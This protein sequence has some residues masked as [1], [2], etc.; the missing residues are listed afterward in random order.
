M[1]SDNIWWTRKSRIQTAER[2]L[3]NDFHTQL[4]LVWYSLFSAAVAIYYLKF[5]PQSDLVQ[6]F[7]AIYSVMILSMSLFMSG[8]NFKERAMLMKQ[9]YEQLGVL[10]KKA[11]SFQDADDLGTLSKIGEDYQYIINASENHKEIDYIVTLVKLKLSN[12]DITRKPSWFHY[13]KTGYYFVFRFVY[14]TL[15][16]AAPVFALILMRRI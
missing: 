4:I 5:D 14:L 11:K 7:M 12:D 3:A 2:L 16:Y 15:F 10:Y 6:V 1:L 13:V 9:C 8:R